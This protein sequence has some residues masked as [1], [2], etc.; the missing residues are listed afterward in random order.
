MDIKKYYFKIVDILICIEVEFDIVIGEES[1]N[2]IYKSEISNKEKADITFKF[3][4]VKHKLKLHGNLY[5]KDILYIYKEKYGFVRE[6]N[7]VTRKDPYAW[8]LPINENNYE[9]LY[10]YDKEYYFKSSKII[11]DAINIEEILNKYNAFI[12]HS[13]LINFKNKGILFSAP[14]GIGKSTQADLW[15]RYENT[16][17]I[18]GD[19][20]AIRKVN[21]EWIAYGLPIAGSSGIY[22]NKKVNLSNIIILK[23]G[24]ENKLKKISLRESFIKLYQ[25]TAIYT[26]DNNFKDNIVSMLIDLVQTIP[27]YQYEC[28]PDKSAVDF[29]KSQIIK[30]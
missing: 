1:K 16:E 7:P 23:Q 3:K 19:R 29:L 17:I 26:W 30:D 12:L 20:V 5:H 10:M 24:K 11:F 6:F 15:N 4:K 27:V 25:E 14:S 22:K 2:F 13:S 21:G 28:L 8:L 18:N 9:L